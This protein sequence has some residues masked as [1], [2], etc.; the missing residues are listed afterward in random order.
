M[1]HTVY[2]AGPISGLTYA[3]ATQ[4]RLLAS[5]ALAQHGIK[6]LSPLRNKEYLGAMGALSAQLYKE[7]ALSP[8]S[9]Q[10]G[11]MTRDFFD[12][13][14]CDVLLVNLLG[15]RTVS[16]GTVLEIGWV[17]QARTP[18]VCCMEPGNP[19][20]HAM[21]NEAIGFKAASVEEG[22]ALTVSILG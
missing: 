6:S 8:L 15:T 19:H 11:V 5:D 14:R 17:F 20:D 2:L 16:I 10:R 21:V 7:G 13:T 1:N 18:V 22:I 4:W 12:A 3:E 9:T